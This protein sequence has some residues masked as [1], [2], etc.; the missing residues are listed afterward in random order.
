MRLQPRTTALHPA[1]FTLMEVIVASGIL[2]VL[3]AS[4]I[5]LLSHVRTVRQE[6]DRRMIAIEEAANLMESVAALALAGDLSSESVNELKLSP[7]SRR[8][9][10]AESVI[11]LEESESPFPGQRVTVTV[12]WRNDADEQAAPVE[13]TAWFP[14][15]GD[16]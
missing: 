6:A 15:R 4:A 1:G 11:A 10:T 9:P 7:A 12:S 3:F 5:P 14:P 13:I 16:M 2:S 8:L